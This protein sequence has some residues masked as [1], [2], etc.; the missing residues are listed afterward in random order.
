MVTNLLD[1]SRI[2]AGALRAERDVFELDDLVSR[3]LERLRP[4]LGD[5]PLEVDL[6]APPVEVD[7]I[8]LDSSVTNIVENAIKYTPADAPM[9]ISARALDDGFVRLTIEDGGPGVPP[10]ALARLFD[11]FYRVPGQQRTS[12][13][14][15]GIGLAVVRGLVEAMGGR[16]EARRSELGGLAIDIDLPAAGAGASPGAPA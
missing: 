12:R 4:R 1:L 15:T 7:P 5:R 6:D 9:R 16:V 13:S 3:S 10:E 2:E 8:F 14:G 11:K